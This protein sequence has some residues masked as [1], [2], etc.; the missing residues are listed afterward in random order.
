MLFIWIHELDSIPDLFSWLYNPFQ[1]IKINDKD[2]WFY[3]Q[4]DQK[5]LVNYISKFFIVMESQFYNNLTVYLSSTVYS[6]FSIILLI[7]YWILRYIIIFPKNYFSKHIFF[8]A[9]RFD[10]KFLL[11]K[12]FSNFKFLDSEI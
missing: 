1:S 10:L 11:S 9:L 8:V 7:N 5:R 2:C 6:I 12:S 3:L 4:V